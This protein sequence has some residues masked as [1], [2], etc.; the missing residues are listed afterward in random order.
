M[1]MMLMVKAMQTKVGNPLRKLV[2]IKLADN[3]NDKGECWPSHQHIADQCEISKRSVINHINAL[4]DMNLLRIENRFKN[5]EKQSNIYYLNLGSAGDALPSA[6]DA[7]PSAGDALPSAGDALPSAGDALPPSAGDAHRT[8]HSFE[9]I[10][11]PVNEPVSLGAKK[12]APKF[13][14]IKF[15]QDHNVS[16]L[17]INDFI[18]HRKNKKASNTATALK[19]IVREAGKA[20]ITVE[21]AIEITIERNWTGFNASWKWQDDSVK[22][23]SH[24]LS[25]QDYSKDTPII[26]QWMRELEEQGG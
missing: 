5:N 21:R 25:K 6:G 20:G 26:P 19:G 9:P 17:V 7:L 12:S 16:D 8:S 11:E 14:P 13:D 2:L 15:L 10:K 24:D 4:V 3:A 18:A 22:T 1:S 23:S